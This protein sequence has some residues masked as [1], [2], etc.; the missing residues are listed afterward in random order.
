MAVTVPPGLEDV[1]SI[2]P[3]I[4]HGKVC[5]KGRRLMLTVLLDNLKD[6]MSV[7]E[8]VE[9]YEA[10]RDQVMAVVAWQAHEMRRTMGIEYED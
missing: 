4:M 8:F 6:G 2:D 10:N 7:D 9:E 1:L 5:F 3:E